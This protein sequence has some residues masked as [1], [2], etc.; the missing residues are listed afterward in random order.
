[1][2]AVYDVIVAGVSGL[3]SASFWQTAKRD[4]MGSNLRPVSAKA[5]PSVVAAGLGWLDPKP[6]SLDRRKHA[7]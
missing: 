4:Q 1:M 2:T 7:I 3:G 5:L 6:S